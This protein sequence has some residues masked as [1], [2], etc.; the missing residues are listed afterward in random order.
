MQEVLTIDFR[1][2]VAVFPLPD[3]VLFPHTLLP[4][5]IFEPR[6]R[7]MVNDSLDDV[8][9]VS[10]GL[11]DQSVTPDQYLHGCP[12]LRPWVCVGLIRRYEKLHDGRFFVV[13]QGICRARIVAEQTHDPYRIVTLDPADINP[14]ED[15]QLGRCRARLAHLVDL[16][17]LIRRPRVRKARAHLVAE[18]PMP[19]VVDGM[20][21][22][23]LTQTEERYTMLAE[24]NPVAR[25]L[26]LIHHLESLGDDHA[27]T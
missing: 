7:K 12:T 16:P 25:A 18:R 8:G 26:W 20:L 9:L 13:L 10:M 19:A 2:P 27:E 22:E 11:F 6:Y 21:A 3:C 15:A 17:S 14:Q 5:H 4:L 1:R 23:L 24:V